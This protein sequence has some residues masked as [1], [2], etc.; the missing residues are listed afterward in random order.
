[1]SEV[2]TSSASETTATETTTE[3]PQDATVAAKESETPQPTP[4]Q[5][6]KYKLKVDGEEF[7]EE[8]DLNDESAITTKLQLAAA[9]KKRMTEAVDQKRK[10]YEII[11]AFEDNPETML[12]RLGPKGRE[13]AEKFLLEQIKGE[14]LSPEEKEMLELREFKK[15]H[16][17]ELEKKKQLEEMTAREK[18]EYQI[19]QDFQT[20]IIGAL[21]KT[22][23]PKSPELVKRTAYILK[24][25]L[26]LGLDLTADQLA[27]EVKMETLG[28]LKSIVGDADGESLLNLLGTD[29]A[30]KI[31]MYDVQKLKEKQGE[32]FQRQNTKS[33]SKPR[34]ETRPMSVDEWKEEIERRVRS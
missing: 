17:E 10:A 30:K 11:K 21:Q 8:I 5:L 12:Q 19:A 18:Q 13:I 2:D 27:A 9:A 32:I 33:V 29:M 4:S 1:M 25:N 3:A 7:E 26:E 16:T 15:K 22:G 31:R 20:T 14:M 28:Y 23:L 6:R 34:E 24:K